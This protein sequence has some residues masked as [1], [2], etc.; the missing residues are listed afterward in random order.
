MPVN[1]HNRSSNKENS[2]ANNDDASNDVCVLSLYSSNIYN[3]E[4]LKE[5]YCC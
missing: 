1:N 2:N 4:K 5:S 3:R